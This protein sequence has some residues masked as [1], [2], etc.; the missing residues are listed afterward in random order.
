LPLEKQ[1]QLGAL[2]MQLTAK[3][4]HRQISFRALIVVSPPFDEQS[5]WLTFYLC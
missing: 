2:V 4:E 5:H 3:T 1:F